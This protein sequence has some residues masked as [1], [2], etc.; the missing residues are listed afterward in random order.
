MAVDRLRYHKRLGRR[1]RVAL[2]AEEGSM[3]FPGTAVLVCT[4][5]YS[6]RVFAVCVCVCVSC[7][8]LCVV[9]VTVASGPTRTEEEGGSS[10]I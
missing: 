6:V 7:V 1:Q 10:L 4:G 9:C 8:W 2:S 5:V 3:I